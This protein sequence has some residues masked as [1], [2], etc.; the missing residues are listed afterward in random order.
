MKSITRSNF[1]VVRCFP[2]S[3]G[4]VLALRHR[5]S[6]GGPQVLTLPHGVEHRTPTSGTR[7]PRPRSQNT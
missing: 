3:L 4:V 2:G 1:P 5:W 7:P 6:C